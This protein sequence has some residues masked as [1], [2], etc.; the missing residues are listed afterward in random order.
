MPSLGCGALLLFIEK[1]FVKK[2][3]EVLVPVTLRNPCDNYCSGC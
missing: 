1:L 3:R 2:K